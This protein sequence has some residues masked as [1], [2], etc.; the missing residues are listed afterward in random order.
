MFPKKSLALLSILTVVV[1][2]SLNRTGSDVR[3]TSLIT[4]LGGQSGGQVIE[5]KRCLLTV[6]VLS[7]PLRDEAI[8]DVLW[9]RVDQQ[10]VAPE[11]RRALE[12]NGLRVGLLTGGLPAEVDALVKAPPPNKVEPV[13][14]IQPE[15][16]P[17]QIRPVPAVAQA[18]LFLSRQGQA[19]GKE[20]QDA[21]GI[22]RATPRYEGAS[23]VAVRLVPEIQHGPVQQS[24]GAV[25]N[26][27]MY[28]AKQLTVKNGQQEETLRELTADLTLE[29]DQAIVVG[30]VPDR[31]RS[32]GAFMLTETEP[33]SDRILQKVVLI[34]ALKG[35]TGAPGSSPPPPS[36]L[37]SVDPPKS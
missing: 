18:S 32:L 14:Y 11:A 33:G 21:S 24:F 3:Q 5:P 7:R 34:W 25:T 20:Y 22:L 26:G 19:T 27:G 15:G 35:N 10:S 8:N 31:P 28:E 36:G 13:K 23:S 2:C 4:R 6:V 1:G 37:Q 9:R 29:P 30:F 17:A 12:E 16:Q